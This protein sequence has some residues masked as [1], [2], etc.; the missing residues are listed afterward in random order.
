[1][2]DLGKAFNEKKAEMDN[3][4]NKI[5]N[6]YDQFDEWGRLDS[7]AGIIEKG[8][9]LHIVSTHL[10]EGAHIFDLGSG[11]GR[12]AIEFAK[13]GYTITLFDLSERL[14]AIAKEK[15][16]EAKL[17]ASVEG[18]YTGNATKLTEIESDSVDAVFCCGPFYHIVE[19]N[20]RVA[21][22][23][24]AMRVCRPQGVL[25]I[26]FIPRFSG[27]AGL[28]FRAANTR[29]QVDSQV[30]RLASE[31]GIFHNASPEGFQEGYYPTVEETKAFWL[32]MGLTDIKVF[33]TRSFIHQN[34]EHLLKIR[35]NDPEL[36]QTIIEAHRE[37]AGSEAFIEAGGHAVLIGKKQ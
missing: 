33:S 2:L 10:P 11:P 14:I 32:K 19:E 36:F 12:Y 31:A 30:F 18:F 35:D 27:L 25:I 20:S 6:Y 17:S 1:M 23:K 34:E 4:F 26:G 37:V 15:F 28:L 3:S 21:A 24:E 9:V 8:E 7:P 13:R 5:R 16:R 29:G 22:A